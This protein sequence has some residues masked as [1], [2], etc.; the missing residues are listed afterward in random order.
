LELMPRTLPMFP[1]GTVLFP[2]ASLPLHVFEERYRIMIRRVLR[3]DQEFGV[4]LIERGAEVGGGDTR[5]DVGTIARVVQSQELPDG[6]FALATVGTRRIRVTRW[7]ADDPYPQAEVVEH[8]DED[9]PVDP[10]NRARVDAA[11]HAL[12]ELARRFEV[13]VIEPPVLD[14]DDRRAS[15][16]A[17]AIAPIGPLDAQRVLEASSADER[18]A[19]LASLLED[20]LAAIRAALGE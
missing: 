20:H 11:L 13:N 17:A 1:L 8:D 2:Y 4:V 3:G 16:E 12:V 19:L 5:F 7:L 6:R 10:T 15:Y 9:A 18:L 14:D